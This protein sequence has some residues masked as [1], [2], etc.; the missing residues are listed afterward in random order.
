MQTE[1]K[2]M[3][4]V[5]LLRWGGLGDLL[6]SLPSIRLIRKKFPAAMI[7]L[8]CQ[9][10]YGE[11]LLRAGIVNRLIDVFSRQ[12]L[13]LFSE[14]ARDEAD[15]RSWLGSFG[16]VVAWMSGKKKSLLESNSGWSVSP[17]THLIHY[18]AQSQESISSFFFRK[19]QEAVG[20]EGFSFAECAHL[21]Y[22]PGP[23]GGSFG[24]LDVQARR[25]DCKHVV[26]HPGSGSK[27]KCWPLSRFLTIVERL[28]E[29]EIGG[30]MVTGESEGWL[31]PVLEKTGFPEG[32]AW[33]HCPS[34]LE[35]CHGLTRASLY[36]GNDSGI[37]HLAAACG[38]KVLALFQESREAA[39]RPFGQARILSASRV[40]EVDVEEVWKEADL[41][42]G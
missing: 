19:T 5:L 34:L 31:R 38:T 3:K 12:L 7:T 14:E 17:N 36:I 21:G 2:A 15:L 6:V 37:T 29:K 22:F 25:A 41:L 13:L 18:E 9:R 35:L 1:E 10:R 39:W 24:R 26:I 20:G 23:R 4:N 42:L 8:V 28:G 16:L 11:L 40:E 27:E 33:V 30:I 32:W